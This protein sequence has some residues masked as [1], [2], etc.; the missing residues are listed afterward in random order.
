MKQRLRTGNS[1]AVNGDILTYSNITEPAI[2]LQNKY[3]Y[4]YTILIEPAIFKIWISTR[5]S[6]IALFPITRRQSDQ[7]NWA[8]S[9][10]GEQPR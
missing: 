1:L 3:I 2:S 10:H 4:I 9:I 6:K 8:K 5:V 7:W